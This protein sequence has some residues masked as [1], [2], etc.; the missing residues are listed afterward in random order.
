[1]KVKN[2][3]DN[4]LKLHNKL[5]SQGLYSFPARGKV[6]VSIKQGVYI[7]YNENGKV[8]HVGK[9]D[10]GK[11]GLNQRLYNHLTNGSSFSK[12]YLKV[13]NMNLR[14]VGMFK[15]L[16]VE[17]DRERAL[18]EA[19]TIGKLCPEHLGTGVNK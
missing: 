10:D 2:E 7:I 5:L 13:M 6:K 16:E 12:K 9:T 1:M 14:E 18:L 3:I 8:L 4:I 11:E 17:N 15:F 19:L